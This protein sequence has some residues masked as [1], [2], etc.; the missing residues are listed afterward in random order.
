MKAA[1]PRRRTAAGTATCLAAVLLLAAACAADDAP[2]PVQ[3]D[4]TSEGFDPAVLA[5]PAG[6]E[7]RFVNRTP[8]ARTVASTPSGQEPSGSP[9]AA[10]GRIGEESDGTRAPDEGDDS[11][12]GPIDSGRLLEGETYAVVLE[13]AGEY[14][15]HA[16]P[17]EEGLGGGPE[18]VDA[19]RLGT[20]LVGTV[21]VE[22]T[23]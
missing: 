8:T 21:R 19:Q 6:T 13:E 22:T 17:L 14:L 18:R 23:P 7:V 10:H 15:Y 12:D 20:Q 16:V 4:L 3:V 11:V 2:P 5:V 9:A 1:T